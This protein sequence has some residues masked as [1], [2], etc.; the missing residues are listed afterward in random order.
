PNSLRQ[1]LVERFDK[2]ELRTLYFDLGI[3]YDSLP[4]EG[5][6]DK[7]RELVLYLARH[8][9]LPELL[10]LGAQLRPEI[11]WDSLSVQVQDA[12]APPRP[13]APLDVSGFV[14]REDELAY[15]GQELTSSHLAVISGMAGVGKTAL[16]VTLTRQ[17]AQPEQVFWHA[18]HEDEGV[19]VLLY[20]LAGFLFWRGQEDMWRML[21]GVQRGGGQPPPTPV[22]LDY[23]FQA[24]RGQHCLLCLDDWQLVEQDPLLEQLLKRL[25]RAASQGDLSL[26]VVSQ[27]VPDFVRADESQ[28]LDGLSLQDTTLLLAQHGLVTDEE[29][30]LKAK[31][32]STSTLLTRADLMSADI[33]ANL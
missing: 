19:E 1:T 33:A 30:A 4:G 11:S 12:S 15:F 13:T 9:R 2:G 32:H 23:L 29:Q 28:A 6:S 31:V 24:V 16:A 3:G 21:H 14:G 20:K 18:F 8:D 5:T 10:D 27:S 26:L 22:L 25:C 7:A 17:L